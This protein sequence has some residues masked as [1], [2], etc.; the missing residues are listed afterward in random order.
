MAPGIE[1]S[2]LPFTGSR[3]QVRDPAHHEPAGHLFGF[4]PGAE[5]CEGNLG[6]FGTD[7]HTSG[8]A[9]AF[10]RGAR[11][12]D[13]PVGTAGRVRR[14]LGQLLGQRTTGGQSAVDA[15]ASRAFVPRIQEY[16]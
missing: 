16:P 14:T 2:Q 12:S 15:V 11:V 3:V 10:K 13:Q 5:R 1:Q 8:V 9:G 7:E 6:D 4:L